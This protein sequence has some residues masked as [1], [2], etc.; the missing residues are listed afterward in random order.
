MSIGE[1]T[2]PGQVGPYTV[3]KRVSDQNYFISTPGRRKSVKL[4]HVNQLKPFY[5]HSP[6]ASGADQ[7]GSMAVN[8]ALVVGTVGVVSSECLDGVLEPDEGVLSGRLKN[9]ETLKTL[10]G[11]VD[12]LPEAQAMVFDPGLFGD[13]PSCTNWGAPDVVYTDHNLLTFFTFVAVPQSV[14]D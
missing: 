14:A 2:L 12:Y 5:A 1:F 4:F 13:V 9:P 8:P 6:S 11:L 3:V 10:K 7:Q